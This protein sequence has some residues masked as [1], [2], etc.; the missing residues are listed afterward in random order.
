MPAS[1][2]ARATTLIP[3][4]CPSSPGLPTT[5]RIG[6]VD[7]DPGGADPGGADPDGADPDGADP[8][9]A[10]PDGAA[11]AGGVGTVMSSTFR[12]SRCVHPYRRPAGRHTPHRP[13]TFG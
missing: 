3:R 6:L 1:R 10:D 13:E 12:C 5:T 7:P 2:S 4:S 9:G 8:D 11:S